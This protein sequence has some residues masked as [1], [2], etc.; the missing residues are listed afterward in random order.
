V[1]EDLPV[2]DSSLRGAE[3]ARASGLKAD[4]GNQNTFT[5][6]M[7]LNQDTLHP[8][9]RASSPLSCTAST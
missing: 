6:T 4:W 8:A 9:I 3:K 1:K 7:K 5:T 2:P